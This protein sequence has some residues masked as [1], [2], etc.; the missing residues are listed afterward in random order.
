MYISERKYETRFLKIVY[1]QVY[2]FIRF[3][4]CYSRSRRDCSRTSP[5]GSQLSKIK[6]HFHHWAYLGL[7]LL[8]YLKCFSGSV[9]VFQTVIKKLFLALFVTNSAP[10]L[11]ISWATLYSEHEYLSFHIISS[12]LDNDV[13]LNAVSMHLWVCKWRQN[14]GHAQNY[15][16]YQWREQRRAGPTLQ[17]LIPG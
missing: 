2:N 10:S 11:V 15:R 5:S 9:L 1:V 13:M 6:W 7:C 16:P 8:I 12:T 14:K 4:Y 3:L 17:P